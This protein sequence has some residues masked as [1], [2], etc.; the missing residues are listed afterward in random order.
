LVESARSTLYIAS[1]YLDVHGIASLEDAF[2]KASSAGVML[3]LLT[4]IEN[5]QQPDLRLIQGMLHLLKV[6]GAKFNAANLAY[7][8]RNPV[9]GYVNITS[10]LHAKLVVCDRESAY[11]GS[12]DLRHTGL[13][14]NFEIGIVLRDKA[15]VNTIADLFETAWSASESIT[16]QYIEEKA[17]I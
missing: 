13:H 5:R 14:K 8:S 4:R 15:Q 9:S 10:A 2:D 17:G 7:L 16:P 12:A 11:I 6:F 1:P 3:Q